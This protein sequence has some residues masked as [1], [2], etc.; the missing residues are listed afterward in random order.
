MAASEGPIHYVLRRFPKLTETFVIDEVLSLE[1]RGERVIVDSLEAPFDEPRHPELGRLRAPIRSVPERPSRREVRLAHLGLMLRRP[2]AWLRAAR[3]AR[4]EGVWPEFRRAGL[5]ARRCRAEGARH[6]HTH[7]AYYAADV[8]GMAAS[9]AGRPFTVTAHAND[10]W[11]VNNAPHLERRLSL[12]RGVITPTEYNAAHLRRVVPSV[13]VHVV[14][15]GVGAAEAAPAP[16]DGPLLCVARLVPKKGIDTLI[17]AVSLLAP[18]HPRLRLELVGEGY[19]D[20]ELRALAGRLGVEGRVDFRGP[21]PPEVVGRAFER[22][23]VFALACRIAPDGD[24]DGLPVVLLEALARGLPVVTTDVVG[25]PEWIDDRR[26]GLVVPPERPDA[27]AQAI[28]E[29]L[30]DRALAGRLGEAGRR[31]ARERLSREAATAA[32]RRLFG[33]GGR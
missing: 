24:R 10:I 27:L 8:A 25:I 28:A 32:M 4:R 19:L 33:Q 13:P 17:D 21:Q 18:A 9:L 16:A 22:C 2:I 12:A 14:P 1:A 6:V 30:A 3:R 11:Q 26:T 5:V 20:H 15:Y 29:L 31:L 7:F 23:S